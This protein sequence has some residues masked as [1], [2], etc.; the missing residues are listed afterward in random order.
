MAAWIDAIVDPLK[1]AGETAQKLV[2][3]RDAIKTGDMARELL[4]H[5]LEAQ[6]ATLS[7]QARE[8]ALTEEIGG[9]K[10]RLIEFETWET[11]KQRYELAEYRP[12]TFAYAIKEATRGAEP[13]HRI[14]PN[15]Y[16]RRVKSILQHVL[17]SRAGY[18]KVHCP[19]CS[20]DFK[21]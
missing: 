7:A 1:A 13:V 17:R 5:I 4:A 3:V 15:C 9:L 10:A 8:A 6:Q 19:A 14:C 2:E 18:E 20:N 12:G 11:E 16:E 21:L